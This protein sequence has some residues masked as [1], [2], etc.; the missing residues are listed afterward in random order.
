MER[1]REGKTLLYFKELSPEAEKVLSDLYY[2]GNPWGRDRLYQLLKSKHPDVKASKRAVFDWLTKQEAWQLNVRP[3]VKRS[4]MKPITAGVENI[5]SIQADSIDLESVAFGGYGRAVG[6]V[7]I[8]S[9]KLWVFPVRNATPEES[10]RAFEDFLRKGIKISF[11]TVDNGTE[12]LGSFPAWCERHSIKLNNTRAHSPWSNGVIE[13]RLGGDFKR[14]LLMTM[15]M[16]GEKDWVSLCPQ[17]LSN[18]ND[19]KLTI[20]GKTPNELQSDPSLHGTLSAT[21]KAQAAKKYRQQSA[22]ELPVGTYVRLILPYDN[23]NIKKASK[24]GYW[25]KEVY[26][27][28]SV[29]RSKKYVNTNASYRLKKLDANVPLKGTFARWQILRIPDPSKMQR[30]PDAPANPGPVEVDSEGEEHYEVDAILDKHVDRK[31]RVRWKVRWTG[32]QGRDKIQWVEND[33][34][35]PGARELVEQWDRTH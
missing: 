34:I 17:V 12:W 31:G 10:V 7:D 23:A 21:M 9:R 27:I 2:S 33:D 25:G 35:L 18:L 24:V 15:R 30:M 19:S 26:V 13:K 28:H 29:V 20:A 6:A 3:N 11:L 22:P 4:G 16:R 8:F 14:A 32:W 5:G 1:I